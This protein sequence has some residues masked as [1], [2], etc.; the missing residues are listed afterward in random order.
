[1]ALVEDGVLSLDTPLDAVLADNPVV[2]PWAERHPVRLAHLLEHTAGLPGS[3]FFEG[4]REGERWGRVGR[5]SGSPEA[6]PSCSS[7]AIDGRVWSQSGPR[8]TISASTSSIHRS[9]THGKGH[10]QP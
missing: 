4:M 3:S 9:M 6:K 5:S 7:P 2:N 10:I 8:A 1:M